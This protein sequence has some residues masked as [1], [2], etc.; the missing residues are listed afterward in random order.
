MQ[1]FFF[2]KTGCYHEVSNRKSLWFVKKKSSK[3]GV[4]SM[5]QSSSR[6][7]FM[8]NIRVCM[9][10]TFRLIRFAVKGVITSSM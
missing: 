3:L 5:F 10:I 1:I 9:Q 7:M 2:L 8:F 4:K 6:F